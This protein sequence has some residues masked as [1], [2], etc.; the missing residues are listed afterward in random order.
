M[1]Q[2]WWLQ[3]LC[4]A[5]LRKQYNGT[6]CNTII[7]RPALWKRQPLVFSSRSPGGGDNQDQED[8]Q[9]DHHDHHEVKWSED[10]DDEDSKTRSWNSSSPAK[11]RKMTQLAVFLENTQ[12]R[13]ASTWRC[14]C[15]LVVRENTRRLAW[16]IWSQWCDE[17]VWWSYDQ[18]NKKT[19]TETQAMTK[20][21]PKPIQ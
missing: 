14:N 5:V 18:T 13:K 4:C 10:I 21:V 17:E 3:S 6:Q 16:D 9:H 11:L 1:S 15:F 7:M 2:R 19:K 20:T 12:S 8:V